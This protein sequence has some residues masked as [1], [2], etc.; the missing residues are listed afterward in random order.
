MTGRYGRPPA[1][2]RS[3][4]LARSSGLRRVL[5]RLRE[6]ALQIQKRRRISA[7]LRELF[8]VTCDN[9]EIYAHILS[10]RSHARSL[11]IRIVQER[12]GI[13]TGYGVS[14]GASQ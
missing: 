13:A 6:H 9:R 4:D 11:Y 5:R 1:A 10:L 7:P 14:E 12:G 8:M 3:G 2:P